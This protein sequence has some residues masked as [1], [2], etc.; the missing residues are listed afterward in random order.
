MNPQGLI[1]EIYSWN[2]WVLQILGAM[3]IGNCYVSFHIYFHKY[4]KGLGTFA[5]NF[6]STIKEYISFASNSW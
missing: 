1:E 5:I 2:A 3:G 4:V 6:L